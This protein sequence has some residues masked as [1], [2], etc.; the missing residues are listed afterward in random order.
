MASPDFANMTRHDLSKLRR[1][2]IKAGERPSAK[3]NYFTTTLSAG[4]SNKRPDDYIPT[5]LFKDWCEHHGP[6]NHLT[7]EC[8][9]ANGVKTKPA[10]QLRAEAKMRSL[11]LYEREVSSPT[12]MTYGRTDYVVSSRG[13]SSLRRLRS[14]GRNRRPSAG[15]GLPRVR[16]DWK[17]VFSSRMRS[18]LEDASQ[19]QRVSGSLHSERYQRVEDCLKAKVSL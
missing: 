6:S 17:E 5:A 14:G 19:R 18:S 10:S 16:G 13:R 9:T 1:R 2:A 4:V 11:I 7:A 8:Y 12:S 15:R 3:N